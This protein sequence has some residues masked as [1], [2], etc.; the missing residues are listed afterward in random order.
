MRVAQ[1]GTCNRVW[2]YPSQ[3]V[4]RRP[5]GSRPNPLLIHLNKG[6]HG[7]E[8]LSAIGALKVCHPPLTSSKRWPRHTRSCHPRGPWFVSWFFSSRF[9]CSKYYSWKCSVSAWLTTSS[10]HFQL[11]LADLYY[12]LGWG[13]EQRQSGCRA[14]A[15][16]TS[17][18]STQRHADR[19]PWASSH[20]PRG[21]QLVEPMPLHPLLFAFW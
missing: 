21:R 1:D 17:Q 14:R 11:C 6:Q 8:H 13:R 7:R 3:T 20:Q 12:T 19:L 9:P 15:N 10:Q 18:V 4:A 5:L 2:K 16:G